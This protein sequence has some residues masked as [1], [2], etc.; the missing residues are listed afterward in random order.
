[1]SALGKIHLVA[2]GGI[3][4]NLGIKM[5]FSNE[6]ARS[7]G[8]IYLVSDAGPIFDELEP[9]Q[10][11]VTFLSPLRTVDYLMNQNADT[12]VKTTRSRIADDG[13]RLAIV[14]LNA[15]RRVV[16]ELDIGV[17]PALIHAVTRMR[18]NLD[19]C[20]IVE[21]TSLYRLG[22]L[23]AQEQLSVDT[24]DDPSIKSNGLIEAQ[25]IDGH[26]LQRPWKEIALCPQMEKRGSAVDLFFKNP[27][28]FVFCAL[29]SIIGIASLF[30]IVFSLFFQQ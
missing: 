8:C 13:A 12:V 18:T 20:S 23:L 2:D 11:S 19:A 24:F 29:L 15:A 6:N 16:N 4:D 9:G 14:S 22:L 7:N 17:E 26:S 30:G 5:A 28:I 27:R 10:G 21:I 1:M 3:V 25:T